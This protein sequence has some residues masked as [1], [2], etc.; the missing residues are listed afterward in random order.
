MVIC[1]LNQKLM[2]TTKFKTPFN[3]QERKGQQFSKPSLTEPDGSYTIQEILERSQRGMLP[4]V[5]QNVTYDTN[6]EMEFDAISPLRQ[7]GLDIT[8][9]QELSNEINNRLTESQKQKVKEAQ[10]AEQ[11][12][13]QA[14]KEALR[15]EILKE[16]EEKS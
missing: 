11:Q 1:R 4:N 2:K 16:L 6:G 7:L 12:K 14:E 5:K 8:D 13:K 9:V 15:A 3:S 10:E